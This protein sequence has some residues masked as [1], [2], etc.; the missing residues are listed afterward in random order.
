MSKVDWGF[1]V[2]FG[3]FALV[4]TLSYFSGFQWLLPW[5][6]GGFVTLALGVVFAPF[7]HRVTRQKVEVPPH[8][9]AWRLVTATALVLIGIAQVRPNEWMF[10]V[11]LALIGG[12]A[13]FEYWSRRRTS[14]QV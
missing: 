9:L 1:F 5:V 12:Q 8:P 3:L 7:V 11:A 13:A 6:T 10:T 14:S 4:V 2:F